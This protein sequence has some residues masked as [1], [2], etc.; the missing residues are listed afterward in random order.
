[1]SCPSEAVLAVHA[2]GE[3]AS[4]EARRTEAH[5]AECFRCRGLVEALRG[6]SRLLAQTLEWAAAGEAA[7]PEA[8]WTQGVTAVLLVLAA[9]AGVQALWGWLSSLG[10]QAPVGLVD[11]RSLMLSALFEAFFFLLREGAAMLTSFVTVVGVLLFLI[12]GGVAFAFWRRRAPGVLLLSALVALMASPS[13]ALE[14]RVGK[15][16]TITVPSGETIDDTLLAA[17]DT[18][19]V[20]GVVTGNLLAFGHSV[21]VRGTV[22]GDLLTCA[23]RV[24]VFGSVEGNIITLGEDVSLRG[25]VGLSLHAFGKH[26]GIDKEAKVRGD[27]MAFAQEANVDGDVG[28][29]LLAFAGITNVRGNVARDASAWTGKLRVDSQAR[30][31][32]D[33]TAHVDNK[34]HV[35]IDSGATVVGKTETRVNEKK[36][37]HGSR[38]SRPSFYVWK[39]IWLAAAFLTG[40]VLQRL[41]PSLFPQRLPERTSVWTSLAIGFLVF[42]A[43]PAAAIMAGVTLVGLPLS[44]LLLAAWLGALYVSGLVVGPLVGRALL[45]RRETPPP[46]FALALFV[47]LLTLTVVGNLPF[48]GGL[49]RSVVVLLGLG[50]AFVQS[51]RAWRRSSLPAQAGI[52]GAAPPEPIAG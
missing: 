48:I 15:H 33:L 49:V 5:L 21:T 35:S 7:E 44:L 12:A 36:A 28:R 30:V 22:K 42:V 24:E 14:R 31:G 19:S 11:Q 47:G 20:D 4:E 43:P 8:P 32:G 45:A 25:P 9:G 41:S 3:L 50:V 18:V 39:M 51:T 27:A 34:D 16:G 46:P 40:L 23:Q 52:G 1:M 6:E 29:D 2:D 37:S 13:F 17:G 10:E 26:V 38:Y